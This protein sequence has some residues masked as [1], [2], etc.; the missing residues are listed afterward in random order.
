MKEAYSGAL[1]IIN[2]HLQP[3]VSKASHFTRVTIKMSFTLLRVKL[4]TQR[5]QLNVKDTVRQLF[6]ST[7]QFASSAIR[8]CFCSPMLL[9]PVDQLLIS[10]I[11]TTQS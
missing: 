3:H 10:F 6:I 1:S 7:V 4:P 8:P 11:L 2:I 5:T 9:D